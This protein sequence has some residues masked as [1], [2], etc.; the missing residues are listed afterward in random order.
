MIATSPAKQDVLA[1]ATVGGVLELADDGLDNIAEL[2]GFHLLH[3]VCEQV[4]AK[5]ATTAQ[6]LDLPRERGDAAL[7][8]ENGAGIVGGHQECDDAGMHLDPS[9]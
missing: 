5:L 9:P 1:T 8:A 4:P 2:C 7:R 3:E 6:T